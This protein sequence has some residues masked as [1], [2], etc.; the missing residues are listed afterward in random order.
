MVER[1]VRPAKQIGDADFRCR[2]G[3][4]AGERADLNHLVVDLERP[5]DRPQH[6]LNVL[7]Q[8]FAAVI[9][10]VRRYGELVAAH[11]CDNRALACLLEDG[12]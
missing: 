9:R 5:G 7:F 6:R 3:S 12:D 10:Q 8:R 1:D 11:P 2:S 4:H